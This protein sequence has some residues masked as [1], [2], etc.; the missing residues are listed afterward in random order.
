MA[1]KKQLLTYPEDVYVP[2]AIQRG[3]LTEQQVIK[4]YSRLLAIGMKRYNRLVA[5]GYAERESAKLLK[6]QLVRLKD[7][8]EYPPTPAGENQRQRALAY[9]LTGL[10]YVLTLKTGT[11]S[12][13]KAYEKATLARLHKYGYEF[14]TEANLAQFGAF[15]EKHRAEVMGNVLESDVIARIWNESERLQIPQEQVEKDFS[16]FVQY[17]DEIEDI[18]AARAG[19]DSKKLRE[20]LTGKK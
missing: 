6:A 7:M 18:P 9:H 16:F 2:Q 8:P 19:G 12:G 11:V 1:A 10:S 5:A 3:L 15:M 17:L 20:L 4:E 14:V 13:I